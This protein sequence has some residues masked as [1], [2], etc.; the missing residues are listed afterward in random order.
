MSAARRDGGAEGSAA[1]AA[2]RYPMRVP[3]ATG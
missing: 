1:K 3:F 2:R